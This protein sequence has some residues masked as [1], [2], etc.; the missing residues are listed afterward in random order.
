MIFKNEFL[1]FLLTSGFILLLNVLIFGF[2]EIKI[3][4]TIDINIH[5]T[6]FVIE[7]FKIVLLLSVFLFFIVYLIK[8]FL[9]NFQSL[10]SNFILI[11]STIL[12][13]IVLNKIHNHLFNFNIDN[14][15]WTIYPPLSATEIIPQNDV[16]TNKIEL[17]LT[18]ITNS[19][20]FLQILLMLLL[21]FCGYKIGK[22]K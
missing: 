16:E 4:S 20:L 8:S 3:N 12:F 17:Y 14:N 15:G 9:N 5:D 10:I 2:D 22:S 7:N 19:I 21:V 11:I 13:L 1:W 6:Y 18:I